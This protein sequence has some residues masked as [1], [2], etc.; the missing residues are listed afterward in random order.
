MSQHTAEETTDP[1]ADRDRD[2]DR[3]T[4]G[5]TAVAAD[6]LA[7]LAATYEPSSARLLRMCA[8]LA[9]R[10]AIDLGCGPGHSTRLLHAVVA[11][12]ATLGIDASPEHVA[13]ARASAPPGI[14]Y[15]VHDVTVAPLPGEAPPDLLYSRFLLTH[16]RDPARVL[17]RWAAAAAARASLV[18]EETAEMSSPHPAF[19]LYYRLVGALQRHYG[20]ELAIGR[21]LDGALVGSGWNVEIGEV[22]ELSLPARRMALL[23]RLNLATWRHDPYARATFAPRELDELAAALDAIASGAP[24]APDVRHSMRQLVLMK[25]PGV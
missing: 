19:R 13:R 17:R 23:H 3:Y 15:A 8:S 10:R 5:D 22:R 11:P 24:D 18:I 25:Q 6:R 7:L 2:R 21:A 14:A 16:L 20:Q 12:A 9:P 4:F 1:V